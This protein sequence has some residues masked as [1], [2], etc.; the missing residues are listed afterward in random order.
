MAE[1]KLV[2]TLDSIG[3]IKLVP[4]VSIVLLVAG[5]LALEQMLYFVG[6]VVPIDINSRDPALFIHAST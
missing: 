1:P 6:D 3:L 4:V 5:L 2:A